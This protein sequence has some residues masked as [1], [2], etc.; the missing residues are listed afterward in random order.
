MTMNRAFGYRLLA[1]AY[2][3]NILTSIILINLAVAV[4]GFVK[5][6]ATASYLGTSAAADAF[7]VSYFMLDAI[8]PNIVAPALNAASS[9]T[10]GHWS[11][12]TSVAT[13]RAAVRRVLVLSLVV[14]VLLTIA[15]FMLR[16]TLIGTFAA[17]ATGDALMHHLY[18]LL[19]PVVVIY[20]LYAVFAGALQAVGKFNATVA[21][22]IVVNV[23]VIATTWAVWSGRI[24]QP[25]GVLWIAGAISFGALI[26]L[27]M[28]AI[29]WRRWQPAQT[30]ADVSVAPA[31]AADA[32]GSARALF[33]IAVWYVLYLGF[34]QSVGF[35]ERWLASHFAPGSVAALSYA[36][37]LAQ[38]P[39]WV[40]VSALGTFFLPR[41]SGA[42]ARRD[43]DQIERLVRSA[44]EFCITLC[45]PLA[46]VIG[47]LRVPI[48][49][50]LFERGAF[51]AESV[52]QTTGFLAGYAW[53]ILAQAIVVIL[54]RCTV[55]M[56]SMLQ[57]VLVMGIGATINVAF[58]YLMT[59]VLGP[60]ALGVGAAVG[61]GVAAMLLWWYITK[62]LRIHLMPRR[63]TLSRVALCNL[64]IAALSV[65]LASLCTMNAIRSSMRLEILLVIGTLAVMTV[66]YGWCLTTNRPVHVEEVTLEHA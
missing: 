3:H 8:G 7:A 21:G 63:A 18:A 60:L 66:L 9:A 12:I 1:M 37:R 4:T 27:M 28:L 49:Q 10:F 2:R 19:L 53:A 6:V 20:P 22:P 14:V 38:L 17:S 64:A 24:A 41:L 54:F 65:G 30:A 58:D 61:Y 45:V 40:F 59:P 32:R 43:R 15:V 62:H 29:Q 26:M 51:T 50:I 46:I 13:Y 33:Q 31:V 36:Y 16:S 52:Q 48:I 35:F 42:L 44:L 11:V 5:D 55:A 47:L 34:T 57:P 39:N 23:A 25:H 56:G